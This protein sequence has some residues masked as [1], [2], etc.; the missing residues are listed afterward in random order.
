[1]YRMKAAENDITDR[2]LCKVSISDERKR[3][4]LTIPTGAEVRQRMT[5]YIMT[6]ACSSCIYYNL[7]L[8]PRWL[9][10]RIHPHLPDIA[11]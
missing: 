6:A 9:R 1:M 7:L 8:Q 10:Q 2:R 11:S 3:N 4:E 5:R